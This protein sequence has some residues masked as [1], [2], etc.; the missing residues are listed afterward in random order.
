MLKDIHSQNDGLIEWTTEDGKT[1]QFIVDPLRPDNIPTEILVKL[2]ELRRERERLRPTTYHVIYQSEGS[3][4]EN[5]IINAPKP[6][7]SSGGVY[8]FLEALKKERNKI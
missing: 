2:Q 6:V 8:A 3:T 4:P 1:L 5:H 7:T